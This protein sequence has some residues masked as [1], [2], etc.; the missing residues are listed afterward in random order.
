MGNI[1]LFIVNFKN[2]PPSEQKQNGRITKLL[3]QAV[4]H[5]D[6]I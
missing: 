2:L 1:T 5:K 4:V 3:L 6:N